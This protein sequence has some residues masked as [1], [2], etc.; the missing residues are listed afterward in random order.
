MRVGKKLIL[1][2]GLIT[3]SLLSFS[4]VEASDG[5][6]LSKTCGRQ[7]SE[8][9]SVSFSN[10]RYRNFLCSLPLLSSLSRR[11][12]PLSSHTRPAPRY[13]LWNTHCYR[14]LTPNGVWFGTGTSY[15]PHT[16]AGRW[17]SYKNSMIRF[18]FS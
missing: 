15:C 1:L 2:C 9:E 7:L 17:P 4:K 13:G 8:T 10:K 11:H 6:Y 16:L 5:E 3:V 18:I 12:E 14:A